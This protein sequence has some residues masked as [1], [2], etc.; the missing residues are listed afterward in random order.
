MSS[1]SSRSGYVIYCYDPDMGQKCKIYVTKIFYRLWQPRL[2][3]PTRLPSRGC[4]ARQLSAVLSA[5]DSASPQPG[6]RSSPCQLRPQL[7]SLAP[8]FRNKS[9][10]GKSYKFSLLL[11]HELRKNL[12]KYFQ[13]INSCK[14]I[15]RFIKQTF[16]YAPWHLTISWNL[17]LTF[18][19]L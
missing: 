5:P 12:H 17:T 1:H 16:I 18:F 2:N 15:A 10:S 19:F 6:S 3:R 14:T 13:W 8:L 7:D 9:C 4:T 11:K